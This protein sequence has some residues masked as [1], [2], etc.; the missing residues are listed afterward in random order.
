M[1]T[2]SWIQNNI[3]N[4]L[5]K[6]ANTLGIDKSVKIAPSVIREAGEEDSIPTDETLEFLE[7]RDMSSVEPS[8]QEGIPTTQVASSQ[9]FLSGLNTAPAGG[10]SS[11]AAALLGGSSLAVATRECRR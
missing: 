7:R 4:I 9:P 11:S 10:G 8:I 6:G 1:W 2:E 3:A 5:I